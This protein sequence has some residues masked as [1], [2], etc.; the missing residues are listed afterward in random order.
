MWTFKKYTNIY[1]IILNNDSYSVPIPQAVIPS[2]PKLTPK[3]NSDEFVDTSRTSERDTDQ[4]YE[5]SYSYL[6]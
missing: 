2:E 3:H 4:F 6:V 5:I 1:L